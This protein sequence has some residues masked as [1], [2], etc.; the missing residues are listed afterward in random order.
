MA[1]AADDWRRAGQEKYLSGARLTWKRYQARSGNSEHEHCAFCW[2]KF[3]DA[4]YSE[5]ARRVLADEPEKNAAY[6]YAT[7]GGAGQQSAGE[8]WICKRCF[9]DFAEEFA[10]TTAE[11]DPEAWP[12]DTPEPNPRPT[13]GD[14]KPG[15]A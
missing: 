1:V 12:Y 14:Y 5:S 2:Q 3:L 11:S 15:A 8:H 10:W 13:E 4:Q 7:V 9:E 6:G